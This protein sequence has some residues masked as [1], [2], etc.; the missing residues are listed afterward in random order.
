MAAD[1]LHK[2]N[3]NNDMSVISIV[4]WMVL[5]FW[6][7][8]NIQRQKKQNGKYLKTKEANGKYL[9]PKNQLT[10]LPILLNYQELPLVSQWSDSHPIWDS[11]I[12]EDAWKFHLLICLLH[13]DLNGCG[14]EKIRT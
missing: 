7:A 4:I 5:K 9:K 6:T 14:R 10:I 13:F 2:E 1:L 11:S 12:R 8:W 3:N